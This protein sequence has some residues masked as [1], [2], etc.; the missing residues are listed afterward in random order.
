MT[1]ISNIVVFFIPVFP[2]GLKKLLAGGHLSVLSYSEGQEQPAAL[3]LPAAGGVRAGDPA[4]F[5]F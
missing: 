1:C 3:P 5:C 4:Q 2:H